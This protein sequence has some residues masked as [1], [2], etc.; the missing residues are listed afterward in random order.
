VLCGFWNVFGWNPDIN[1]DQYNVKTKCLEY[2]NLDIL[3]IAES[4]LKPGIN[5]SVP[6]YKWI[7]HNRTQLH[8]KARCGS[9]GVGFL[10]KERVLDDY[11]LETLDSSY[12][13]ILWIKLSG[14]RDKSVINLCVCYLPLLAAREQS[15]QKNS[16]TLY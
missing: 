10:I 7:G 5:L 1:S 3:G 2:L 4:K 11:C 15:M 14:K 16:S 12:E 6:G 13:G 9:G 8:K